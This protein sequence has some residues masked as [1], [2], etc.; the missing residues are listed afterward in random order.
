MA[1]K[2]QIQVSRKKVQKFVKD[3]GNKKYLIG[4]VLLVVVYIVIKKYGTKAPGTSAPGTKD[5]TDAGSNSYPDNSAIADGALGSYVIQKGGREFSYSRTPELELWFNDDGTIS[6]RTSNLSFD[7]TTNKLANK[8]VYYMLGYCVF[9]NSDGSYNPFQNI[10]LPDGI[11]TIRQFVCDE[12]VAPNLAAFTQKLDGWNNGV[13]STNSRLSEIFLA[14][15]TTGSVANSAVPRWLKVSRHLVF[16]SVAYQKDWATYKKFFCIVYQNRDSTAEEYQKL[17][18]NTDLDYG[19]PIAQPKTW[20]TPRKNDASLQDNAWYYQQGRDW[21]NKS[22]ASKRFV[23][24]DQYP[25]DVQNTDPDIDTKMYHFY[26]GAFDRIQEVHGPTDKKDTGLYGPYGQDDFAKL[27][28]TDLLKYDRPTYVQSL[29]T[30]VHKIYDPASGQWAGDASYYATG[31]INVRNVNHSL[32]LYNDIEM[33]PYRLI[34]VNERVKIGTKTYQAQDREANVLGFGWAKTQ[35]LVEPFGVGIEY[36]STGEIIPF[37]GGEIKS[38]QNLEIPMP[39]EESFTAGFWCTLVLSGIGMW[40]APGSRF[41]TDASKLHWY[42]D[43]PVFWKKDGGSW[44]PYQSGQNGAPVSDAT[45]L[46]HRLWASP[47]DAAYAGS[48]AVWKIADRI[49]TLE[50]VSYGSSRGSF[51]AIPGTTGLHLNG[52]GPLNTN[53]FVVKD[54]YDAQKGIAIIGQ[55]PGGMVLV[56]Y[57]GFLSPHEYEDN[58]VIEGTNLGRAYGRQTVVKVI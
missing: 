40:N 35:S 38:I 20:N 28:V 22:G 43:Q 11:Y 9:Q 44:E 39:W 37:P 50:H 32:Y 24:T 13:N 7:G 5:G 41:G 18:I 55:G 3:P 56:Y 6:D 4:A 14:I 33:L 31:A 34:Y 23:L 2:K 15:K 48:E 47:T 30:H 54:A 12:N 10:Y 49:Q 1:L 21:I 57:N 58:V 42:T 36:S 51:N 8:R 25:E 45:G 29:T 46:I 53:L 27:L 16:P 19:I 26:K 52:Y 17:G